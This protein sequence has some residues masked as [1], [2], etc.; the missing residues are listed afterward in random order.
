[1]VPADAGESLDADAVIVACDTRNTRELLQRSG[2]TDR[3]DV[4]SVQ[5]SEPFCI[6]RL[7]LDRPVA[8]GRP[9]FY[10]TSRF[11]YLDSLAVYSAFQEP[12]VSQ[13]R[14]GG[15]AVIELHAYAI[16]PERLASP[17]AIADAM[18]QEMLVVLPELTGARVRHREVQLQQSFTRFAPGDHARRPTTASGVPGLLFAGDWVKVDAPVALMEGATVSGKLA[19]NAILDD[20][21]LAREPIPLVARTGPLA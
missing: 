9:A 12:F 11:A 13:A 21:G 19:A 4:A 3:I 8:P 20:D 10:T 2:L 7:W 18:A 16:P 1:V 5:E 15:G 17:D 6:A 14:A